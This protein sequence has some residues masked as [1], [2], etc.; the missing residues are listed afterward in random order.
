MHSID[1]KGT[2]PPLL[3]LS[4]SSSSP[5]WTVTTVARGSSK[6]PPR[7]RT[8]TMSLF[9]VV[10]LLFQ[11]V[12][13]TTQ[14]EATS[15]SPSPPLLC[16]HADGSTT[17]IPDHQRND[18]YCDCPTTGIDEPDTAA[19]AGSRYW[20]GTKMDSIT[21]VVEEIQSV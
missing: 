1:N 12:A 16:R 18:N 19:C 9:L 3:L 14:Q 20:P 11:L 13:P 2:R 6:P 4:S 7:R 21:K 10:L 8:K 15:T 17:V 5:G